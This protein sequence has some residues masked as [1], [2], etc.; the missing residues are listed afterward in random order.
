MNATTRAER[1]TIGML[2]SA[3][4]VAN[5]IRNWHQPTHHELSMVIAGLAAK[6]KDMG[7]LTDSLTRSLVDQLDEMADEVDQD[8]VNQL[9][10]A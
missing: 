3:Q 10:Q 4:E 1:V 5:A 8:L 2:L 7:G 6:I 9:E